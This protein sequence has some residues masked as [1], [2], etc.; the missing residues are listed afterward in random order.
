MVLFK[1]DVNMMVGTKARHPV[2]RFAVLEMTYGE[3]GNTQLKHLLTID[4]LS[5]YVNRI[6]PAMPTNDYCYLI[7]PFSLILVRTEK[8]RYVEIRTSSAA[9]AISENFARDPNK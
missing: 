7:T 8:N 5:Y 6:V 2:S 4:S 3:G 1:S 9:K